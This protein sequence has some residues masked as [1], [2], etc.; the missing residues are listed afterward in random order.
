MNNNLILRV[1]NSPYNDVTKSSVLSQADVDNNFIYLKGDLIYAAT[2]SGSTTYLH[3]YNGETISF[4]GGSGGGSGGTVDDTYWVSG[5]T[6]NYS[7][8]ANNDSGLDAL[9]NYSLAEGNATTALGEASHTE[10]DRTTAGWR[11]FTVDSVADNVISIVGY[12]DLTVSFG[13]NVLYTENFD[14]TVIYSAVTWDG[15]V[16]KIYCNSNPYVAVGDFVASRHTL[17][18]PLG[19]RLGGENSHA[20]GKMTYAFGLNSHTEG[21]LTRTYASGG[22]AEGTGS[23][24]YNQNAH[25][26]GDRTAAFGQA[27][28]SEGRETTAYG[29][30]TH[31]EG[32]STKA[33]WRGFTVSNIS[34]GVVTITGYGDLTSSF[35]ASGGLYDGF[36]EVPY[37]GISWSNPNFQIY[38]T[39][40]P[41]YFAYYVADITKLYQPLANRTNN[42]SASHSEGEYTSAIG[43]GSH[44]EGNY[45]TAIHNGSH[46]EGV[47]SIAYGNGSH[48]EGG[49]YDNDTSTYYSGGT[50]IGNASHAE[51]VRATSIGI[52]SH[53]DGYRTTS[54]GDYSHSEGEETIASGD[55]SHAE[56]NN[57]LSIGYGS[58]AEGGGTTTIGYRSHAEGY[59]TIANGDNS[60]S[61]G[62]ETRAGW[63]GFT[64]DNYSAGIV[65]IIGY[66]DL[67][68]SF[69]FYGGILLDDLNNL[70]PYS[71]SSW[72][73]PNFEINLTD[74]PASYNA[75][76]VADTYFLNEALADQ[77]LG[78]NSH[79]EGYQ[80]TAI[81]I[82]SHAEGGY[83][84]LG[85]YYGGGGVAIGNGS[86]AEGGSTTSIGEGSHAE[87]VWSKALGNY[88]HAEGYTTTAIGESSH[89][90]G[91]TTTSIGSASHTEGYNTT[92]IGN[93][94]HAQGNNTK[95]FGDYSHAEGDYS[96]AGW[97]GFTVDSLVDGVITITG[98]GDLS[99]SFPNSGEL[100]SNYSEKISYTA[101]TWNNPNFEIYLTDNNINNY[102]ADYVAYFDNLY[103]PLADIL[104]GES[105]HAEGSL[106]RAA[107]YNSHAEGS[108]SRAYGDSSHAEGS[109]TT[110]LGRYS[111][112]ENNDTKALGDYSH[113]EGNTTSAFGESSHAE[114]YDTTAF[115]AYSHAQGFQTTAFGESSHAEGDSTNAIGDYSSSSGIQTTAVGDIS[116][117]EGDTT[118]AF[119]ES[120]HAEGSE[121]MAIGDQSHSEGFQTTAVGNISHAEGSNT[122]SG[123]RGFAV[124][125][126]LDGVVTISGYGDL[127][128][129]FN[130]STLYNN[131]GYQTPYSGVSWNDPNFE[132]YLT[133]SPSYSAYHV[134]DITNLYD[135]LADTLLGDNSHSEGDTTKAI[136]AVS[137][138]E[139]SNTTTIGLYSHSE[140]DSTKAIGQTSH[141]EGYYTTALSDQSHSEGYQTTAMG[142]SSHAEGAQT[143]GI[144]QNSHSEGDNTTALGTGSHSEGV[145][146]TAG[147]RGFNVS[148]ISAGVVTLT[149]YGDLS[150][151]FGASGTLLNNYGSQTPYSAITWNDPNFE[152]NLTD[153][154]FYSA[155][156]VADI[157]NL[158]DV[159]GDFYGAQYSHAEGNYNTTLGYYSH[160]EGT[161]NKAFG[162]SSH[163]E[164]TQTTAF[165]ISSHAEGAQT[166]AFGI[167]SHAE[168][169]GT[170]ASGDSSHAEGDD[171]TSIGLYSH[172]EGGRTTSIGI[173]SHAEG[174][175]S[176]A[177][178]NKSHAEGEG[179]TSIGSGSHAEGA[180]TTANGDTS[181]AEGYNTT[182]YFPSSHSEG[183]E[184]VAYAYYSHAEG[185]GTRSIGYGSH[186][187][188]AGTIASGNTSHAEG[189][190]YN[191]FTGIYYSGGTAMGNGSHAEGHE[192]TSIGNF[193]HSEGYLTTAIGNYSFVHGTGSTASASTSIVLGNDITGTSSNTVYVSNFNIKTL[194]GGTSINNLGIDVNGN[195]VTGTSGGG[196]GVIIT[197]GTYFSGTTILTNNTGGTVNISGYYAPYELKNYS[198]STFGEKLQTAINSVPSGAT[199]D[200]TNTIGI[201][202]QINSS[203]N[204]TKPLNI[205]LGDNLITAS[206]GS[207]NSVFNILSSSVTIK[208]VSSSSKSSDLAGRTRITMTNGKWHIYSIG[209]NALRFEDFDCI[210]I[211]STNYKYYSGTTTPKTAPYSF[212]NDGS[213]GIFVAEG[214]PYVVGGGNTVSKL[215]IQNLFIYQTMNS[216]ILLLGG[217][218]SRIENCRISSAAGH[219]IYVGS[220]TTTLSLINNYVSSSVLAG[221]CLDGVATSVLISNATEAA[222]IGLWLKSCQS[223][224]IIGHYSEACGTR[225]TTR[226]PDNTGL[227]INNSLGGQYI[228]DIGTDNLTLFRGSS[229]VVTGGRNIYLPNPYSNNPGSPN[230]Q[231]SS[232]Q[233]RHI[234]VRGNTREIYLLNPR[235]TSSV[236]YGGTPRFDIGIETLSTDIPRDVNLFFNPTLDG[237]ITPTIAGKYITQTDSSG[238]S[239]VVLDQGSNTRIQSGANVWTYDVVSR[240]VIT[241]N[242]Y[243]TLP[244][245]KLI[246]FT[247]MSSSKAITLLTPPSGSNVIYTFK[248]ESGAASLTNKVTLSSS[249]KTIN[250]QS[251]YDIINSSYGYGS[252]YY[253]GSNWVT[254]STQNTDITITGGTYTAGTATFTNNI[255]S[256]FNVTGFSTSNGSSITA[257]NNVGS[258][259]T[260][261]WNVSG[262]STNYEVTLTGTSTLNLTN[263]RNGDYGTMI[264]KQDTVGSRT[265][266]FGTVN[267]GAVSHKVSNGGAGVPTLTSNANAT[268]ILSFTYNGTF[269]FWTVGNDYN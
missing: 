223:V 236:G 104:L 29:A 38:L 75:S 146:T 262:V 231:G 228:T 140:G 28:H 64:V 182:S 175:T 188:G 16:F 136:G 263:V 186:A 159:L 147:W 39:N 34:N 160:A 134:A 259:T 219:G 63:K 251:T 253:N 101:S 79:A 138:A 227:F 164:G 48:A 215:V 8:K 113:A 244:N 167:S 110:A 99:G 193:S 171:T 183:S 185:V 57:T 150:G 90:E 238:E 77:L 41:S 242:T 225:D 260:I 224:E 60:H 241:G 114:G 178:G 117:A 6:G 151:S 221:I 115:G 170:I 239:T 245:D 190:Y 35:N 137:H 149:D 68:S 92:A 20:S 214:D 47:K 247:G 98:Y 123:W 109:Y 87:G 269:M 209:N 22:H 24:S 107:G 82:G 192:T 264:V 206:V 195:V 145:G 53:A 261:T 10:G 205:F 143:T 267:G 108:L 67:S 166:T 23:I 243:T 148:S 157:N 112:S 55:T 46:A 12:G 196:S 130:A 180:G 156:Y 116:H 21:E 26:E 54:I 212:N 154:P 131:Y 163:A 96:R 202:L 40:S 256:T 229:Y 222:G 97:R 233:T 91:D 139:G 59:L 122:K 44:S 105:N 165:G 27:S 76:Y 56:G 181:H 31:A 70:T 102:S 174:G 250:G 129:S 69:P 191:Q 42:S 37:S 14:Y 176:R 19:D 73:D 184:T 169:A 50:A 257:Y 237:T 32:D 103:D 248:D 1:L 30:K 203:I 210:G 255:G 125:S 152:I 9:G 254:L 168:G 43:V 158:D 189:G 234:L 194:G 179:T 204:V 124:S 217:I 218:T 52:G 118:T 200:C 249:T 17:T 95:S 177:I 80:S 111:H 2:T 173:H 45:T 15:S 126:V 93:Y 144:G 265:L 66:G 89:A 94:S 216:G 220:S 153:S 13:G 208:G 65:T 84:I 162:D 100:Y 85:S 106:T 197:G 7:L 18:N 88:S 252:I 226:M 72:N 78:D 155:L 198:G 201:T 268:D 49:Y 86:H 81:G 83:I 25:A 135:V 258:A 33:G 266:S 246:V 240:T 127:T 58:H 211:Q 119:G 5:S 230:T 128:S 74:S 121:T 51:G 161:N 207:G 213:G 199:I 172:A 4:L 11:G 142:I 232:T 132:I 235:C 3:K 133:D 141:A 71:S 61:E 187:E 62:Y 36:K 120:S